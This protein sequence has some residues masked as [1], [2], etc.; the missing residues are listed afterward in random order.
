MW[1][2]NVDSKLS[3]TKYN[4]KGSCFD[5]RKS[6]SPLSKKSIKQN[7]NSKMSRHPPEFMIKS[8]LTKKPVKLSQSIESKHTID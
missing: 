8:K 5:R 1:S 2:R 3:K 4:T 7:S 6:K